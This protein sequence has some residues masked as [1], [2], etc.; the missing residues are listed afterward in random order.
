M[1]HLFIKELNTYVLYCAACNFYQN[2]YLSTNVIMI[3]KIVSHF[4][5]FIYM[6]AYI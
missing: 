1:I 4:F 6:L 2:N 5:Y 3:F